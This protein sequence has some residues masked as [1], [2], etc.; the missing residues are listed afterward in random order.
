MAPAPPKSFKDSDLIASDDEDEDF[1]GGD[2]SASSDD[3]GD[4]RPAK[5]TKGAVEVVVAPV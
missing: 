5:K 2:S 3:S 4:E 1:L